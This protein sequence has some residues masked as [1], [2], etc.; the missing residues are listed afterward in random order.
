MSDYFNYGFDDKTWDKYRQMVFARADELEVLKNTESMK[1]R[2]LDQKS[3][4]HPFLNFCLPHE[5]GGLGDPVDKKYAQ[6]NLFPDWKDLPVI[7]PR[8][9]VNNKNEFNVEIEKQEGVVVDMSLFQKPLLKEAEQTEFAE[10]KAQI[11]EL[12]RQLAHERQVLEETKQEEQRE[13]SRGSKRRSSRSR[14]NTHKDR[15]YKNGRD[16][17][18]YRD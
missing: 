4:G 17:D 12:K 14:P 15:D 9:T 2:V 7:K 18:G 3:S 8:T 6:L 13:K 5:F 11:D 16:A 10:L 1:K